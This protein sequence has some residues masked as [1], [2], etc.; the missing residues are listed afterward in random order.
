MDVMENIKL[1]FTKAKMDM[2]ALKQ[3]VT[4]WIV[5]LSNKQREADSRLKAIEERIA[6]LERKHLERFDYDG[7]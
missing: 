1:S 6:F 7:R 5:L 3:N 2:D 4:E